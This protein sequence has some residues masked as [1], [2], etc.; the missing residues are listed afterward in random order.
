MGKERTRKE[1]EGEEQRRK[2]EE[3]RQSWG[4]GEDKKE[5]ER[6]RMER[7]MKKRGRH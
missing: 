3:G 2:E 7:K 1:G 4:R 5:G 6:V